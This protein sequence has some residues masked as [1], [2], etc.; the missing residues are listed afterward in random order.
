MLK[1]IIN[2]ILFITIFYCVT[3]KSRKSL[4]ML[5]QNLYDENHRYLKWLKQ[6]KTQALKHYDVI[7]LILLIV[8]LFTGR[9]LTSILLIICFFIYILDS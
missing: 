2:L 1:I 5:Q 4:H 8:S 9:I 3:V 6:N 7:A